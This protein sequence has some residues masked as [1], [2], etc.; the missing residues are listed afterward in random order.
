MATSI[1]PSH[2]IIADSARY[3]R[4]LG[5]VAAPAFVSVDLSIMRC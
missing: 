3:S 2:R 5:Y 1:I 4:E